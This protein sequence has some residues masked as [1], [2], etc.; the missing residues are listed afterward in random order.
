MQSSV[1][2]GDCLNQL[3]QRHMFIFKGTHHLHIGEEGTIKTA[4]LGLMYM[5]VLWIHVIRKCN[6]AP[7]ACYGPITLA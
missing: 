6:M 3:F 1:M 2:N 7:I 4:G 5:A